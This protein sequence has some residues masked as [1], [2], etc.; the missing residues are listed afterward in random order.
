MILDAY[1][2]NP[3]SM[4]AALDNFTSMRSERKVVILGDM[5][6]LGEYSISAHQEIVDL[7]GKQQ[8][9]GIYLIGEEFSRTSV[10]SNI[11]IYKKV[12]NLFKVIEGQAIEDSLILLKGSRGMRMD[13]IVTALE[14]D[15]E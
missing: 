1:N 7:L 6:E 2:A 8:L 9:D 3:D 11:R 10:S 15:H 5:F 14:I 12:E 4:K 13:K